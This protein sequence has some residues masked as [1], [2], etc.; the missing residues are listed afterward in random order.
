MNWND[1]SFEVYLQITEIN[2]REDTEYNKLLDLTAVVNDVDVES[3]TILNFKQYA[4]NIKFISEDIPVVE[5]KDEYGNYTL[6]KDLSQM[7]MMQY[8]DFNNYAKTND[9]VGVLSVF[10]IPKGKEYNKDYNIDDVRKY[11][12]TMSCVDVL[13]IYSF[14]LLQ[15]TVSMECFRESIRQKQMKILKERKQRRRTQM[16]LIQIYQLYT[17]YLRNLIYH[18]FKSWK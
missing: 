4:E 1:I 16:T 15:S 18:I 14:F 5:I 9:Y 6:Q 7:S 12:L 13:S 11:I 10:L 8:I 17:R 3:I 2:E